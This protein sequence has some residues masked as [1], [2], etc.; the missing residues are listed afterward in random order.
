MANSNSNSFHSTFSPQLRSDQK[1]IRFYHPAKP[2]GCF[3]N[4]SQHPI[5]LDGYDWPTTEHYFQAQKFEDLRLQDRVRLAATPKDAAKI[6]RD[7]KL[8]L[9]RDWE[10]VKDSVM[11]N[12][13]REKFDK[14]KECQEILLSTGDDYLIEDTTIS[15]D[16]YWGCGK[17]GRG[18]NMLG[19]LLMQ[20]RDELNC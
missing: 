18:V 2:F 3:S 16:A 15:G 4:F 11:L 14:N 19:K 12:A 1:I 7:R 20:V 10:Q 13:L 8:P 6:G 17:D 9:R 5:H